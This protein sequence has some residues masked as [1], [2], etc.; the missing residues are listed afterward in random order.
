[1]LKKKVRFAVILL[2]LGGFLS[3]AA[4]SPG[5]NPKDRMRGH[6][7]PVADALRVIT[8]HLE[9]LHPN[10]PGVA[11][12]NAHPDVIEVADEVTQSNDDDGVAVALERLVLSRP[13]PSQTE[14][15]NNQHHV[16]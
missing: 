16:R 12:A 2:V 13:K 7:V 9:G 15:R 4:L 8:L 11:V 14:R 1:M 5:M 3:V 6:V 10:T